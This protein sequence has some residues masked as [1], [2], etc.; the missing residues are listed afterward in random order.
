MLI[1]R[2]KISSS[3]DKELYKKLRELSEKTK[4]PISRLLDEAI[5]DLLDKRK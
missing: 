4:V 1:N 2:E 5:E 3:V